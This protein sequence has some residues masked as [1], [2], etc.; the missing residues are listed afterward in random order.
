[1]ISIKIENPYNRRRFLAKKWHNKQAWLK[2]LYASFI[3]LFISKL[4]TPLCFLLL[5]IQIC[6]TTI[7]DYKVLTKSCQYFKH[8]NCFTNRKR[9]PVLW[10]PLS[11]RN[12]EIGDITQFYLLRFLVLTS[13]ITA[14]ARITP[15]IIYWYEMPTPRRFIPLVSDAIT[16]A[17]II[18]P[19]TLPTPP[20][21][22]TPPT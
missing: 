14:T 19:V 5:L 7:L 8:Y 13:K 21:A 3:L 6:Y 16:K 10:Q 9:L 17:P 22:E 15:R 12:S 20:F 18:E 11:Y 2:P 4:L 1:M